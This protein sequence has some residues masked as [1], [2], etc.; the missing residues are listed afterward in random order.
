MKTKFIWFL[1][2]IAFGLLPL[3]TATANAPKKQYSPTKIST[4]PSIDGVLD[5][6]VWK[7]GIWEGGFSQFEPNNGKDPY[8]QTEFCILFDDNYLYVGI[9]AWDTAPDSIVSRLT[10]RDN[11]DGDVVGILFDSYHDLRTAFLLGVS[12]A[13]TRFDQMMTN[14]GNTEDSTWDAI[15]LARTSKDEEGWSAEMRIPFSQLRFKKNGS[16]IWG[17]QVFRKI[18]R[19][20]EM[21]FWQHIPSDAPGI[22][23]LFGEMNGMQVEPRKVFD[24]VPYMVT[25][26][27]RYLQQP[28]NPFLP[29]REQHLKAGMDAKIGL[30]NSFTLD[31]TINPDFGQVEA[32]PSEVNLSAFETFFQEKRPFFIEG[33]NISSFELGLGSQG[34]DNLFYSRRIGRRPAGFIDVNGESW[35]DRPNFSNILGAAKLTGKTQDGLS[36]AIIQTLT[37]ETQAEIDYHG[38]RSFQTIE[39]MTNFFISRIQKDF[40]D[41]NTLL[42][43]MFT[44]TIRRLDDNLSSQMHAQAYSG[45]IDYTQYFNNKNWMLNINAVMSHVSG[46]QDAITLTQMAPARYFQRPDARHLSLDADR[47]SLTGHAGLLRFGKFGSGK[48]NMMAA[49]LWRSPEFEI[50]DLG[51]M[52]EADQIFQVFWVG[53]NQREPRGV[54]RSYNVNLN[55]YTMWTF[56]GERIITGGNINGS[57]TWRNFWSTWAGAEYSHKINSN[58][59]LRGGPSFRLPDRVSSWFGSNTDHRKNLI[60]GL[61]GNLGA[62]MQQDQLFFRLGPSVSYKPAD[63]LTVSFNPS[64]SERFEAMQYVTELNYNQMPRYILASIDQ[65]VFN[66]S[67]RV[68]YTITPDLSVQ[69][70]GQPFVASAKYYDFKMVTN[71]RDQ[72]YTNRFHHFSPQQIQFIDGIYRIDESLDGSV[73]YSFGSPDFNVREFLSNLVIRWE[74]L[75]GSSIFLVWSQT[76]SGFSEQGEMNILPDLDRMFSIKPHNIFLL[77][78]SYRIGIQ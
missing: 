32:D 24:V 37:G 9:R 71:P 1:T 73:D 18:H 33:R 74:F 10:R 2:F 36:V 45:G 47:N 67:F 69:Y 38:S 70:W 31:L 65:K 68:N 78:F 59:H 6:P 60:F 4:P 52:R 55:N 30:S 34:V 39:P 23:H 28:G 48:W 26:A 15:W 46:H 21:S 75:P 27:E 62:G 42:G 53:F 63:N 41:G 49:T 25:S 57:I 56:G 22:V 13:G 64:Y 8:Q 7:E 16:G 72:L 77:K 14:N 50:N 3:R 58:K 61:T 29:G 44:S 76:R 66:F 40:N 51:F 19:H 54:Y 12:A 43:S 11:N 20:G 5:D 35:V 17:L